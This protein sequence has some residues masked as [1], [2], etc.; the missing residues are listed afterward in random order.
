[1]AYVELK[2][3]YDYGTPKEMT[4]VFKGGLSD[5]EAMDLSGKFM[6]SGRFTETYKRATDLPW[7]PYDN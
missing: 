4:V 6:V 2:I 3:T 7:P 5:A 1:M